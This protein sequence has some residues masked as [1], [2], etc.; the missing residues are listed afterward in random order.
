MRL[1][2]IQFSPDIPVR[3]HLCLILALTAV[4][5]GSDPADQET[6]DAARETSTAPSEWP[7][8]GHDASRTCYNP[9]ERAI[10]AGNLANLAQRFTADLGNGRVPSS[11]GPVV[12]AGRVCT[13][14][15]VATGPN[16]FCFDATSG[17]LLWSAD[18]GRLPPDKADVGIGSTAVI[19]SGALAIGG[20]DAAYYLLDAATGA[21]RW[22]HEMGAAPDPFAWSSPLIANGRVYVGISAHYEGV[23]GELRALNLDD[24]SIAAR[25]QFVPAGQRGADIWNSP[26]LSPDGSTVLVATGNDYGGYDGPYGR[27]MLA[28]DPLTLEVR[29]VRQEATA[30]QDLDFGTTP[31]VFRDAAGRVLV[32]A[33]SKNGTFYAY[34]LGALHDGPVWTRVTGLSAGA[35]PGYDPNTGSGGTLF[36]VGDNGLLFG[37]DPATGAD[38]FPP[39][40][41][42]FTTGGLALA[43]GLVF[44]NVGG[45]LRILAADSGRV[46]RTLQPP[47]IGRNFS[48]PAVANGRVYWAAAGILNS[49]GLP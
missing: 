42:G 5:C 36:I 22:R 34:A 8:Y 32:G 19:A 48:G 9:D 28:L 16:Y 18:L 40:A 44:V 49:W 23:E 30:N 45:A 31:V 7:M 26:A 13:G 27:A 38:R 41:V 24:G 21:V 11:S 46:L 15:S 33:N 1:S 10:T 20:G 6:P 47:A 3:L 17:S 29:D 4:A 14:S 37:V 43:N 35:M 2:R 25:R 39:V 12:A